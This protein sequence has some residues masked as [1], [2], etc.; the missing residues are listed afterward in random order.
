MVT[1]PGGPVDTEGLSLE[2]G[3]QR[4]L[5]DSRLQFCVGVKQKPIQKMS[6]HNTIH[7]VHACVCVHVRVYMC[8]CVCVCHSLSFLLYCPVCVQ[9]S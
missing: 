2:N 8:L 6:R 5:K 9:I 1:G 4:E 3:P 7:N